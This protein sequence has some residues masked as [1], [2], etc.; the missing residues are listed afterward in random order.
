MT[1]PP[2]DTPLTGLQAHN[3]RLLKPWSAT[4]RKPRYRPLIVEIIGTSGSGKSTLAENL[5]KMLE[6][7]GYEVAQSRKLP[8]GIHLIPRLTAL[9]DAMRQS[10][11]FLKTRRG[12]TVLRGIIQ[13]YRALTPAI[14][15]RVGPR[16]LSTR[17]ILIQEPGWQMQLTSH[18]LCSAEPLDNYTAELFVRASPPP[19]LAIY[20][21]VDPPVALYRIRQRAR[22][23]PKRLRSLDEE[24]LVAALERGNLASRS[25]A[26]ATE[27]FGI[28][29]F[30]I[31]TTQIAAKDLAHRAEQFV[32]D[33]VEVTEQHRDD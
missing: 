2:I 8:P 16:L 12:G 28:P 15:R 13:L 14:A 17:G 6:N 9:L 21:R 7:A 31:D 19:G 18:Y 1:K 33:I 24:S 11:F 22:G 20:L 10:R 3:G 30:E 23:V 25:L 32:L 29:T 26:R 4:P 5:A 27:K